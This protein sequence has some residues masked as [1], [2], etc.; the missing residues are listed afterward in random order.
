MYALR[1]TMNRVPAAWRNRLKQLP[2]LKRALARLDPTSGAACEFSIGIYLG[3]SPFQLAPA[4]GVRNPVLGADQVTDT[5]ASFVADPFLL[6]DGD[7]WLMFFEILRQADGKGVIGLGSSLDG[8]VWDYEQIVLEESFHL[9]YPQVFAWERDYYMIPEAHASGA[10]RLYRA[11]D[12]PTRWA[13]HAT[14]AEGRP[15]SDPT[16][17]RYDDT[18]WIFTE[19]SPNHRCD[20]LRLYFSD[21][22]TGPWQEHPMSPIVQGNASAA[23]PGGRVL[24]HQ[25][26]LYRFAQDCWPVYGVR[27]QAFEIVVLDRERYHE[28]PVRSGFHLAPS[29]EGWNAHGMHHLDLVRVGEG[30]LGCVDGWRYRKRSR[31]LP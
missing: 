25:G 31:N 9:S 26:R 7:S 10:I 14:L 23:R 30:W 3:D 1:R 19:T 5:C 22:L 21:A 16:I 2:L 17:F 29:G 6:R 24:L 12:F 20:T 11:T 18:W 4:E 8:L 28:I 13:F 27:L 15:F